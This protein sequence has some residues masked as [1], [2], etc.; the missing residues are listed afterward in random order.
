MN[1]E[2]IIEDIDIDNVVCDPTID[3]VLRIVQE[4]QF[5]I[6]KWDDEQVVVDMQT[7]NVLK[8]VYEAVNDNTK[9]KIRES[10]KSINGFCKTI[11]IAWKAIK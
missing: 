5:K 4:R 3:D 7:A 9:M 8:T 6:F 10:F 11:D 2:D 1:I